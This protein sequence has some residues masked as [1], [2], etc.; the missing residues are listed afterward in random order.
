LYHVTDPREDSGGVL[1]PFSA[2]GVE[3]LDPLLLDENDNENPVVAASVNRKEYLVMFAGIKLARDC[4]H[5]G[6][7]ELLVWGQEKPHEARREELGRAP[8]KELGAESCISLLE[9][10]EVQ[11]DE[12][13]V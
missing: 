13:V 11:L 12:L 10:L 4:A 5:V 6:K 7:V 8:V 2:E 1:G 3:D 9:K